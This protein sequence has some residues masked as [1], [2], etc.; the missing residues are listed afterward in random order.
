MPRLLTRFD[1]DGWD[2]LIDAVLTPKTDLVQI[3]RR[4]RR[5]AKAL[6]P[7]G[8]DYGKSPFVLLVRLGRQIGGGDVQTRRELI[9]HAHEAQK[10]LDV[11][12]APARRRT[13]KDIDD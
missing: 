1:F 13:R 2:K 11:L 9:D 4:A 8:Y 5:A 7:G 6:I 12:K 3:Q 10:V